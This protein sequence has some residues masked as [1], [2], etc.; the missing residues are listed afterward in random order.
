VRFT[1]LSNA[2]W[3]NYGYG[4]QAALFTPRL[5]AAGHPIAIIAN[6]GH[7][8]NAIMFNGVTVYGKSF[9]PWAMDVLHSHSETWRADALLSMFDIQVMEPAALMGTKWIPWTPVDHVTIPQIILERLQYAF[10]PITMSKHASAELDR[11]GIDYSYVPCGVDT[12]VFKPLPDPREEMQL[13]KDKFIVGMVAANKGLR[14]AFHQNIMAFAA[15][16]AKYKDCTLYL[17]TLDGL[18]N[19]YETSDLTAFCRTIGL[20]YGYAFDKQDPNQ[21]DVIFADQYGLALGYDSNMM[22]KLYNCFDVHLQVTMGEGFGIPLIEAQ[23]CG[24]P[25]IAGDWTAM[26]ELVFSGYTVDIK[27]AEPIYTDRNA[28]QMLPHP[29]AIGEKLEAAYQHRGNPQYKAKARAAALAYDADAVTQNYWLPALAKI[30]QKI[31]DAP[32]STVLA[33]NLAML[34]QS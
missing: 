29:A 25:V 6:Y 31:A 16:K 8:G 32:A 14:K 1:F 9:H 17:H 27:D 11:L 19:G 24:T 7:E 34:R 3:T 5:T 10:Y 20:T 30:G 21:Y 4:Q 33:Q 22:A 26:P 18:R 28:F 23:A 12:K 2:P 15:L 13:P